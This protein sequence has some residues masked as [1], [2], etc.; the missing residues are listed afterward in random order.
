MADLPG[1]TLQAPAERID[2]L[3]MRIAYQDQ[4]I[5]DLNKVIV[6]QWSKLDQALARI[7]RLENRIMDV[8]GNA[9]SDGRDE[10]PPPHY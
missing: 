3:E 2:T 8:Q 1:P 9:G 6:E 5:E 10:P 4:A 7:D